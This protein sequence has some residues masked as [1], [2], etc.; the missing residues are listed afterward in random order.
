MAERG[1]WILNHYAVTPDLPGGTRHFD[2]GKELVRRGHKVTIFASGFDHT[3]KRCVKLRPGESIRIEDCQGVRFVWVNT[4]PYYGNNRR[5][6]LNMVSYAPAVLRAAQR[7]ERPDAIIGSSMHPFA[8]LAAWWLAR[9]YRARFFFEVRDLWPQTAIDMGAIKATGIPARMLYAWEKFMYRKAER[10]IV[11]LPNAAEYIKG[12]G[13]NPEKIVW[14]PNGVDLERFDNPEPLDPSSEAAAALARHKDRFKVLYAGAHGP[15]N[16]LEVVIEAAAILAR[17]SPDVHF[18]LVGDG[19]EKQGLIKRAADMRIHNVTFLPAV[20]KSQLPGLLR[21]A[22]L[23]VLCLRPLGV[24]RYGVSLNKIFDYLASKKPVVVAGSAFNNIVREAQAG[25]AVEPGTPEALARG[26]LEVY[27][28][29]PGER[30]RLGQNGRL[31][32]EKHH[33]T[34]VLGERLARVLA[35]KETGELYGW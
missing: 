9:K 27:R 10:I 32:V 20:P 33:S 21:Q 12:R 8:A 34:R 4:V 22:D 14:I 11:L 6:I 23:L 30:Q 19:P 31:Y 29:P 17:T 2:L 3:T 7:L 26:I 25:L 18:F 24:Y 35:G 16:G 5:R 28:M 13:V 1:V 15:A